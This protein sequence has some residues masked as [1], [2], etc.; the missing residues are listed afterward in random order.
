MLR[1]H[2]LSSE[3]FC[4]PILSKIIFLISK[5]TNFIYGTKELGQWNRIHMDPVHVSGI[6]LVLIL[7]DSFSKLLE[8]IRFRDRKSSTVKKVFRITFPQNGVPNV[9][10]V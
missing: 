8:V 10:G 1:L 3:T 6:G 9:F 5:K 2:R 7:V 4:D